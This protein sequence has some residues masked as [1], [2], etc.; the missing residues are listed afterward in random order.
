MMLPIRKHVEHFFAEIYWALLF[1]LIGEFQYLDMGGAWLSLFMRVFLKT[2]TSFIHQLSIKVTI[3]MVKTLL[4][5]NVM[6][7]AMPWSLSFTS[8]ST[9]VLKLDKKCLVLD[10]V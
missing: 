10:Q 7:S 8:E 1:S 3:Y 9:F 2:R 5:L 6:S 4:T